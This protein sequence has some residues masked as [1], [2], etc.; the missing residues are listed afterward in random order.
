MIIILSPPPAYCNWQFHLVEPKDLTKATEQHKWKEL[1]PFEY[2]WSPFV[3][4]GK[5]SHTCSL[6]LKLY[7]DARNQFAQCIIISYS[8]LA[9][10][11]KQ[12]HHSKICRYAHCREDFEKYKK[13][14]AE[15]FNTLF[16]RY[17]LKHHLLDG[18]LQNEDVGLSAASKNSPSESVSLCIT[19]TTPFGNTVQSSRLHLISKCKRTCITKHNH[20]SSLC[21]SHNLASIYPEF[22][23]LVNNNGI[24]RTIWFVV[25]VRFSFSQLDISIELVRHLGF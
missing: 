18:S 25:W 22:F 21:N 17:K 8:H 11:L 7:F 16:A 9:C 4:Y 14:E 5:N 1:V 6:N 23:V 20:R 12:K 2:P 10:T 3:I 24:V 13:S 19:L 15:Y